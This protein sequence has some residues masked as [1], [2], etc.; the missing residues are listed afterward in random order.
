MKILSRY[1]KTLL[2]VK[3]DKLGL[4]K[5][6]WHDRKRLVKNGTFSCRFDLLPLTSFLSYP[7]NG[8]MFALVL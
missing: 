3:Q 4:G 1:T 6:A 7:F 5:V 8:L 2:G